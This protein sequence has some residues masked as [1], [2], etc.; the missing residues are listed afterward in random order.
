MVPILGNPE[1]VSAY[2]LTTVRL[3]DT[4]MRPVL[5]IQVLHSG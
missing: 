1:P 5:S 2:G 3:A 4:A